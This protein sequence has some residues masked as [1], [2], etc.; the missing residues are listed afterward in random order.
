MNPKLKN[1][2][3]LKDLTAKT[4]ADYICIARDYLIKK[5]KDLN[6]NNESF[7][8]ETTERSQLSKN[9]SSI[10]D[11]LYSFLNPIK[12]TNNRDENR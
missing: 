1:F 3:F 9:G 7:V 6:P 5:Y 10:D 11:E 4:P 12:S 2:E 8:T